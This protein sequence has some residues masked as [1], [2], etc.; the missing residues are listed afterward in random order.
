MLFC[1][2]KGVPVDENLTEEVPRMDARLA[3]TLVRKWQNIKSLALGPDHSLAQLKEVRCF[4]FSS[5]N[6][7]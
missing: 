5:L 3:E 4:K 2:G 6:Y 1:C 7:H